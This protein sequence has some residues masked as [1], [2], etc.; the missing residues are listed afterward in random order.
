VKYTI[1]VRSVT[2]AYR[3]SVELSGTVYEF[4]MHYNARDSHWYMSLYREDEAVLLGIKIVHSS[5]LL[6]QFYAR[7]IP[8]GILSVTDI[9]GTYR[10][11][12]DSNFGTT[13]LLQYEG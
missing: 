3:M 13:V 6:A 2:D 9:T 5:D 11:P 10:D 7:D 1:P 8:V 12:D 4:S